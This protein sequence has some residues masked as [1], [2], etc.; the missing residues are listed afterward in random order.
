[1]RNIFRAR[2][3]G[4]LWLSL[5]GAASAET[6]ATGYEGWFIKGELGGQMLASD[7]GY[8]WGPGGPPAPPP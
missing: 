1:M 5:V 4:I 3:A 2:L 7:F 8:W 6:V